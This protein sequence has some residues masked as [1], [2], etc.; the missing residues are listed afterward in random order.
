MPTELV[1]GD[2]FEDAARAYAFPADLSGSMDAGIAVAFKKRWPALGDVFAAR[3]KDGKLQLGDVFT[4]K[5]GDVVVYALALQKD[6]KKSK[7]SWLERAVQSMVALAAK[8]D[9]T[10]VALPR[11]GG[12]KV[13]LDPARVKRVLTEIGEKTHVQ[14]VMY[15]QFVRAKA[16]AAGES[17]SDEG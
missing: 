11:I 17:E 16:E 1:K 10:R 14:L 4:W 5:D 15:E 6:G 9:I 2:I 13:G 7:V 12:K 3:C 8:A